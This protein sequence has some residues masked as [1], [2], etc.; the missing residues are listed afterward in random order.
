RLLSQVRC[1]RIP[2]SQLHCQKQKIQADEEKRRVAEKKVGE[3]EQVVSLSAVLRVTRIIADGKLRAGAAA[4]ASIWDP[5]LLA[6]SSGKAE[7]SGSFRNPMTFPGNQAVRFDNRRLCR[8]RSRFRAPPHI[9]HVAI[10][11][12]SPVQSE[13]QEDD[14]RCGDQ[15][16]RE[17]SLHCIEIRR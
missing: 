11:R 5:H 15:Y 7:R 3:P 16:L 10:I 17:S 8:R 12:E 6:G 13:E 2:A 14:P 1:L 9:L 4:E